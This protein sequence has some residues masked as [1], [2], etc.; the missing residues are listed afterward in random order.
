MRRKSV[1]KLMRIRKKRGGRDNRG[2]V[3]VRHKGGEQKRFLR[4][5]DW[6]RDKREIEGK[7]VAIEY[8]PN[9]G[10]DIALVVY[11]DGEKRY[12]LA[13]KDLKTGDKVIAAEK[14]EIRA[15]NSLPLK[16]IPAGV[17]IHNLEIVPGKGGQLIRGAGAMG[18][19]QSK[20]E[21]GVV[22]KLPSGELR[23]FRNNCWAAI[24]QLSNPEIRSRVLGKAGRKRL[25]GVRPTVRGVA[26][27]PDSHPHGGGEGRSGVGMKSPK[28]PWGK[29]TMG[30]RTRRKAKYSNQLIIQRRKK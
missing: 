28:T 8:D 6:K 30:K 10:A 7:I 9:R 3:S 5:I 29:R 1:K 21:S 14:A 27:H 19:I 25:M 16:R 4:K 20:E 22:I 24:G 17:P 15:G 23:L 18:L 13:P 2:R 26:Q 12:I 11:P